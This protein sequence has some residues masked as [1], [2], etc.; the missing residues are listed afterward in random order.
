[1]KILAFGD[2]LRLPTGYAR[3]SQNVLGYF[4]LKGHEVIQIGWGHNEPAERIPIMDRNSEIKGFVALVPPFTGEQFSTQST[5]SYINSW[6]PDLVYNSN[7]FFTATDLLNQKDQ[8]KMF[9]ANYGIVDGPGCAKCYQD[10]IKKVDVPIIPSMYGY[11]Q[12][13]VVN[14]RSIY[15]P[16]GVNIDTF[17]PNPTPKEE[18][19]ARY[20]LKDKFV[21]GCVNRNIWR[22]QYPNLINVFASLKHDYG[23]KDIALYLIADP[24]DAMGNNFVNWAKYLDLTISQNPASPADIMLHPNFMNILYCL[25]DEQLAEAYNCFDVMITASMSEGF[26]LGTIEAQACGVPV[27]AC[28]NTANTELIK[29]HGWLYPTA[30]NV[31]GSDVLIPP[32]IRDI[33]YWYTMPDYGALKLAMLNAYMDRKLVQE[34]STKSLEFARTYQW[35]AVLPKWDEVLNRAE[36]HRKGVAAHA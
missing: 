13:K 8:L 15:I 34:N 36:E 26:G 3:V 27:I 21:F 33:T 35:G 32:T 10:I 14:D 20:G 1:M 16:H 7:D 12:A 25:N 4:A 31:D 17:K 9:F 22:K 2:S 18:L 28:D 30:K 24:G 11:E 29:G 5:V 6:H 23:I 19:K